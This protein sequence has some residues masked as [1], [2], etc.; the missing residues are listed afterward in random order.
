[1]P[2]LEV[3]VLA[4]DRPDLLHLARIALPS[5]SAV[6]DGTPY[7]AVAARLVGNLART[8]LP[9]PAVLQNPRR[10]FHVDLPGPLGAAGESV[11]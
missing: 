6:V 5:A 8:A 4:D 7:T 3:G 10:V 9:I 2:D 1:M 11:G